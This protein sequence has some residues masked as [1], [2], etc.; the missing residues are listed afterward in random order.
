MDTGTWLRCVIF[1]R[2]NFGAF[3]VTF[4][5]DPRM[6]SKGCRVADVPSPPR[7][8]GE[9]HVLPSIH[10]FFY[11]CCCETFNRKVRTGNDGVD[12]Y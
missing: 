10:F 8:G 2:E 3:D 11:C 5:L 6:Y 1:R 4:L 7:S 9:E 12:S